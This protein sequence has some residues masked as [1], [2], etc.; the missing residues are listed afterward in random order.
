MESIDGLRNL[1]AGVVA[2]L[3]SS[4]EY[5]D[6]FL[7]MTEGEQ[8]REVARLTTSVLV[9][10]GAASVT[11]RTLTGVMAGAEASVP[12]LS[13]APEG[14]LAVER[15]V[16]PVGRAATVLSGGPGA[17]ILLQRANTSGGGASSSGGPGRW[18]PAREAMEEPA[19]KYQSQ[20]TRAPEGQVY[21][22]DEVKFDGFR[23]DVL[24]EAKGPGYEHF[25]EQ[26][27]EQGGWFEGFSDMVRQA[28][29]QQRVAHGFPIEWHFAERRVADHVRALFKRN[30]LGR[31]SIHH[32]PP[33]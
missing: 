12:V 28:R 6:R 20:V 16:V 2:L 33:R 11:T 5:L 7:F 17:A 15:V 9:T 30:G 19:R 25:L 13:L 8:I 23:D 10:W 4:P 29:R 31:I 1:P 27:V 3:L 32:T 14:A 21:E 18:K 24:L 26:A 22:V